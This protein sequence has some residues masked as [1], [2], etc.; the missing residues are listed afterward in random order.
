MGDLRDQGCEVRV[1]AQSPNELL[2]RLWKQ[3]SNALGA[4]R[5]D[6]LYI[7]KQNYLESFV[8]KSSVHASKS[9]TA[10]TPR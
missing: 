2:R 9:H 7:A 3:Q 1:K 6:L 5:V 4:D 10:R 8:P